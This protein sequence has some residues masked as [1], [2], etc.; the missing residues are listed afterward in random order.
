MGMAAIVPVGVDHSAVAAAGGAL[1]ASAADDLDEVPAVQR[2]G[3]GVV[4]ADAAG[5]GGSIGKGVRVVGADS[6][7]GRRG[8]GKR[9]RMVGRNA[10]RCE[11]AGLGVGMVLGFRAG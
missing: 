3:M 2:I 5:R 11:G 6:S 7:G 9:V 4:L 10:A 8:V 1:T